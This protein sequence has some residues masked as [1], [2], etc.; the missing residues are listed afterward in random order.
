M[1]AQNPHIRLYH[2]GQETALERLH[3]YSIT[4]SSD[5]LRQKMLD[6]TF[7]LKDIALLG[8]WTTLYA[9]PNT[10]KTLLTLWLLKEVLATAELDGDDVFYVNADDSFKGIVQKTE[11]AEE[12]GFHMVVPNHNGFTHSDIVELM[13]QLAETG[14]AKGIVVIL[15]TLKK[16]TDL[17]HKRESS[18]FGKI[19]RAFVSAGGTLICLAHTNKHRSADGKPMYGGTSD[20][21]D[22][23]DCVYILDKL[24]GYMTGNDVAI[25]FVNKKARGDVADK[26]SFSY[27]KEL[28]QSY[29]DL[30]ES[31]SR[32]DKGKLEELRVNAEIIRELEQ[33]EDIIAA[34]RSSIDQD[35]TSKAAIVKLVADET[36]ITHSKI[37]QVLAKRT[38]KDYALGHRWTVEVGKHNKSTYSI[39]DEA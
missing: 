38:G 19:G 10:G 29:D 35:I 6:D 2:Q 25:E 37:R 14:E 22:D 18:E 34:V 5:T 28:G 1:T 32:I 9:A 33:D 24:D 21:T 27:S 26:V 12:W 13:V 23:C 7:V 4:G 16:F 39:L 8:Q 15:D 36:G 17:M 11:L 20:I 30:V 3:G 31:V